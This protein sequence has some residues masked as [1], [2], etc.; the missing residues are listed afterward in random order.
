MDERG[1]EVNSVKSVPCIPVANQSMNQNLCSYMYFLPPII[2]RSH[3][4]PIWIF[5]MLVQM[6]SLFYWTSYMYYTFVVYETKSSLNHLRVS[7][8]NS[9]MKSCL[10]CRQ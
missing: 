10:K 6:I 9:I 7:I 2:T 5:V 1:E 4:L 8:R 3:R